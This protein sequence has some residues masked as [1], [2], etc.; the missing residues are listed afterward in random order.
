[1]K[2]KKVTVLRLKEI[3][4]LYYEAQLS[5]RQIALSLKLS[6]G[7]ISKYL[8][9]ARLADIQWPLPPDMSDDRL[10][11]ILQPKRNGTATAILAE[12]D[13]A[14]MSAELSRKGMTRQLLWEEYAERH[15]KN[16]YSYSRFTVLYRDWRKKQR[17]SMRQTHRAGEKL[18]VDYAG[19]T[20]KIIDSR[21]MGEERLCAGVC[22]GAREQALIPTPRP[23]GH[24]ACPIG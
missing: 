2:P 17:L 18:F 22:R 3:L 15:P 11:A 4:R 12:P 7:A 20:L 24:K 10:R 16:H 19:L 13:F 9:R 1:M 23:R 14:E 21:T 5:I 6:R 8:A